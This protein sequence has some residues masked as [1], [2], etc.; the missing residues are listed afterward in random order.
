MKEN[1]T[2]RSYVQQIYHFNN[3]L[4]GKSFEFSTT[5]QHERNH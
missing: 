1:T 2:K 5:K 4:H 3:W